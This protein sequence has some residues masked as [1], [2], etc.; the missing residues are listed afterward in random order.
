MPMC[1]WCG[2]VVSQNQVTDLQNG[3]TLLRLCPQC[4]HSEQG[5]K[6]CST[7]PRHTPRVEYVHPDDEPRPTPPWRLITAFVV[8][9]ALL[10]PLALAFL[11]R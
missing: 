6:L 5:S 7:L 10:L 1:G 11:V 3:P 8:L 4:V 9:T 2:A